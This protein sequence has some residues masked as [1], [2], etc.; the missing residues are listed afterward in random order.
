MITSKQ[1]PAYRTAYNTRCARFG[2]QP[3][4]KGFQAFVRQVAC[5][6]RNPVTFGIAE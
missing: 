5:G 2:W 1:Y 6:V 4:A 3:S